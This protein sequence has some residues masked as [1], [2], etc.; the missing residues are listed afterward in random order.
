MFDFVYQN[1]AYSK[2]DESSGWCDQRSD[3]GCF[4]RSSA[5]KISLFDERLKPEPE[6]APP[7]E[8]S[9]PRRGRM[10]QNGGDLRFARE[11]G[12]LADRACH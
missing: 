4:D 2:L 12:R 5:A 11:P 1:E 10:S 7:G 9:I 3:P 6:T 8:L